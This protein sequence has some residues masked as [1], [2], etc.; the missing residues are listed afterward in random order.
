MMLTRESLL[1]ETATLYARTSSVLD[2]VRFQAWERLGLTFPQ[3]RILFRVRALP[4]IDVRGLSEALSISP[5]AVSQQVEKL[6]VRDLLKRRDNPDDR[7][8]VVL[9][10]TE[11]GNQAT[12]EI[13]RAT[14]ERIEPL[15][16][17]LSDEELAD[18]NRLLSRV[19][20]EAE[21][22]ASLGGAIRD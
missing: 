18:L 4:G 8:H 17:R 7:R 14:H 19:L 22:L 15:L 3:L 21:E 1:R 20:Q 16:S 10:L 12:G 13:S 9:E 6:V 2:P 5:S 11:E